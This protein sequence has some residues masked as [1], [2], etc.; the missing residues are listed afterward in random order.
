M[1]NLAEL[2]A[3]R[4]FAVECVTRACE[5]YLERYQRPVPEQ[6]V[7]D[8]ALARI[9]TATLHE[10]LGDLRASLRHYATT[11]ASP[12]SLFADA[13]CGVLARDD[14]PSPVTLLL[15]ALCTTSDDLADERRW[16]R[17]H[18]DAIA[19]SAPRTLIPPGAPR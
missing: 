4:R 5:R 14:D 17:Q 8:W 19:V 3:R 1:V 7:I 9:E 15:P 16:M 11:H 10:D 2:D 13:L 18:L 12:A 6:E